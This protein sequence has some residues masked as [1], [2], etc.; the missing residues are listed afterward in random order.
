[1]L[2]AKAFGQV[3]AIGLMAWMFC[4]VRS[5]F[6]PIELERIHEGRLGGFLCLFRLPEGFALP[7]LDDDFIKEFN[8]SLGLGASVMA[9]GGREVFMAEHLADNF[10]I[11]WLGIK[12]YLCGRMPEL[13]RGEFDASLIPYS[14]LYLS[15]QSRIILGVHLA[16]REEI[17]IGRVREELAPL[18]DIGFDPLAGGFR[19]KEVEGLLVLDLA[20]GNVDMHPFPL[21][22]DVFFKAEVL[23]VANPNG[24][25]DQDLNRNRGLDHE[26]RFLAFAR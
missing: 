11:T 9:I 17:G 21:P 8:G 4:S 26:L 24:R 23:Q 14:L 15:S 6:A 20:L 13:M 1:M 18:H 19:Q 7:V 10:I 16:A 5:F 25:K 2:S 3:Q 12:Q 22:G